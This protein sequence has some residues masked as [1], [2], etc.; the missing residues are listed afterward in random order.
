MS[1]Q[2]A[3][4]EVTIMLEVAIASPWTPPL[5][6]LDLPGMDPVF[7]IGEGHELR[8]PA[9]YPAERMESHLAHCLLR[10]PQD[11]TC[12]TRRILFWLAQPGCTGL[13]AALTDLA[14][15][16]DGR[17]G[18]LWQRLFQQTRHRLPPSLADSLETPGHPPPGEL[19]YAL[20][21][22]TP[23]YPDAWPAPG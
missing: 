14:T 3:I 21:N 8:L 17:G 18:A 13:A 23:P 22:T 16:L 20:F 2:E 4:R 5:E 10:N 12:H 7:L 11:L 1:R 6:S 19:T 15:I 9:W